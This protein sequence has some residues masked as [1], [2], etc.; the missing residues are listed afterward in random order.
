MKHNVPAVIVSPDKP[1]LLVRPGQEY[2]TGDFTDVELETDQGLF[3]RMVVVNNMQE[4][5]RLSKSIKMQNGQGDMHRDVQ[6]FSPKIV[7]G[8]TAMLQ[9][10]SGHASPN[11][12]LGKKSG[13]VGTINLA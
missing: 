1:I 2:P 10:L 7:S 11:D 9:A 4:V 8:A 12:N 13:Y 5:R 3:T 6:R